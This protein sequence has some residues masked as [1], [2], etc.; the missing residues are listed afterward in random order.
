MITSATNSFFLCH[1][2]VT[3]AKKKIFFLW[4]FSG[5]VQ[6]YLIRKNQNRGFEEP[7]RNRGQTNGS[8]S[9]S[10]TGTGTGYPVPPNHL[11]H[12]HRRE[13]LFIMSEENAKFFVEGLAEI[14]IL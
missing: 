9:G 2:I 10:G 4:D 7:N 3:F 12:H 6:F 11:S 8:G 1:C 5:S 14:W 13:E